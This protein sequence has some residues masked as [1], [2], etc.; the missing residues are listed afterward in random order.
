MI[1]LSSLLTFTHLIGLVLGVGA[2]TVK[3]VLLFKCKS[4]PALVPSYLKIFKPITHIIILGL[5][6]LTL[7]GIGWLLYGYPFSAELIVKLIFVL[8]I[9]LI[10]PII[11][12]VIEPKFI[13][14]ASILEE[15]M[16][17][18]FLQIQNKYLGMEIIATLLFYVIII[19][20]VLV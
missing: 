15:P 4:N 18:E 6:L 19:M 12:N 2:A 9:W 1:S 3:L 5:I 16:S 11:D 10:G 14:L 13:K 8:A 7:S 20:W 17:K